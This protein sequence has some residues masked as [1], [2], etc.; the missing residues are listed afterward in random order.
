MVYVIIAI[1]V[2]FLV[3]VLCTYNKFV[4]LK[5]LVEEGFSTMDVYLKKRWDLIP[6][7]VECVKGYAKYEQKTL[8]EVI[9]IRNSAYDSMKQNEK[10]DKS[11]KI[12]SQISKIMM[13]A[14]S[15][16]ELKANNNFI[17]LSK[18]LIQVENDIENS[19]KYYNGTVKLYNIAI[20]KFP[21][22][23]VAKTFGF[24]EEKM[25]EATTEEKENVKIDLK[26]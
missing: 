24:K 25:F 20:L 18:Q 2:I 6:N 19:R 13:L 12:A 1:I 7:L 11:S 21:N 22:N 4:S 8:E 23:I 9:S 5:K 26:D 14:E 17:E 16:P 15:Y 10:I 3:Y